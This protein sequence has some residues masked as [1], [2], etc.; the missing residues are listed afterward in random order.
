[1]KTVKRLEDFFKPRHY[2]ITLDINRL[3]KHY[4]GKITIQGFKV[5]DE[6]PI[7]LHS[8]KLNITSV[9][10]DNEVVPYKLQED[11]LTIEATLEAGEYMIFICFEGHISQSM[12]GMYLSKYIDN[13][14]TKELVST[15]FESHFARR[16]FPCIDEPAAKATFD[17]TLTT[18]PDVTVL[19]NMPIKSQTMTDER[20][21]TEFQT[22]PKM[23][24][25]L[26]AWAYGHMQ[27]KSARTKRGVDVSVYS[28]PAHSL[29]A[30]D[31]GL[32]VAVKTIDFFEQY[33]ETDYPL[34]K[35]DLIALPDFSAGAMENWGLI[36][37]RESCLLAAEGT[38]QSAREYIATVIAHEIAHQWFGNLV[39]MKWWDNLWLNESFA[40]VMMFIAIDKLYPEWNIWQSFLVSE[41]TSALERDQFADVQP[42]ENA[43]SHPDEINAAFDKGIVYAKGSRV[44]CML[45]SY[46]GTNAFRDGLK[47]YFSRHAYSNTTSSDLWQ[48]F[49]DTSGHD[50]GDFMADWLSRPGYPV[51]TV[52]HE[53]E[54]ISLEQERFLIDHASSSDIWPVPVNISGSHDLLTTKSAELTNKQ[55]SLIINPDAQG[56]FI[57]RY[58]TEQLPSL[59]QNL[60]A[61][62]LDPV[63]RGSIAEEYYL[64]AQAGYVSSNELI[65]VLESLADDP[66]DAVWAI[67]ERIIN[68]LRHF[69]ISDDERAVLSNW[70]VKQTQ[71][72]LERLGYTEKTTDSTNDRRV[73][74]TVLDLLVMADHAETIETL[75][76]QYNTR[77][78]DKHPS[79]LRRVICRSAILK[80][81]SEVF[82]QLQVEHTKTHDPEIRSQLANAIC[83]TT[84]R[85]QI[86]TLLAQLKDSQTIKP[87]DITRWYAYI[88][89]N[90]D[91]Q[92]DTWDW[93]MANWDWIYQTFNHDLSLEKFVITSGII[94][95]GEK[96]L[97]SYQQFFTV[98][99]LPEFAR[100]VKIGAQAIKARTDWIQRDHD[101]TMKS[102]KRA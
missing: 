26:L 41:V 59:C 36:T 97:S 49:S 5:S 4:T 45:E 58:E 75:S 52:K 13:G 33:Y 40:N 35:C 62:T 87:Q 88:L 101:V 48:A 100:S 91:A 14:Q 2:D 34:P 71:S 6:K 11:E 51:V 30:V 25:Y 63:E 86:Q 73:R 98:D 77:P 102:F 84:N 55:N 16:V 64:L 74:A 90:K 94:L 9:K 10:L 38:T 85:D 79:T 50:I 37:F 93:M 80:S 42:I 76:E 8:H 99:K 54:S 17:L 20:M 32:E 83:Y 29:E 44:L 47:T 19:G 67:S 39:T 21:T 46:I 82:D 78:I 81:S 18:E 96:W 24:T 43:I 22:T 27:G 72:Q 7:I 3:E 68:Q 95:T 15:Q 69:A 56:H 92:Q 70:L 57:T 89:N 53:G 12:L 31:H 61:Q 60:R 23:S 66:S 1:M 65:D 28:T